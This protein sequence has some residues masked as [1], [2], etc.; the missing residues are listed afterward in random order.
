MT[1]LRT[2][3]KEY[4]TAGSLSYDDAETILALL[5]RARATTTYT[6]YVRANAYNNVFADISNQAQNFVLSFS[7]TASAYREKGKV[8]VATTL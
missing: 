7:C 2:K 3:I 5:Q 6:P 8:N 4:L 1:S